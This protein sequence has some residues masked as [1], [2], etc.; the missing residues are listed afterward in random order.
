MRRFLLM[1]QDVN[2]DFNPKIVEVVDHNDSIGRIGIH[3]MMATAVNEIQATN[4]STDFVYV[5]EEVRPT[6]VTKY[7]DMVNR[8]KA[9]YRSKRPKIKIEPKFQGQISIEDLLLMAILSK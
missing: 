9:T 6:E 8:L 7:D 4:V 1:I 3:E 2:K 5:F